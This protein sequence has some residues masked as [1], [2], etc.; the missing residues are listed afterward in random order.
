M[1]LPNLLLIAALVGLLG[2][3]GCSD[4][5]TNPGGSGGTAGSGGSGASGGTGGMAGTGGSAGMAGMG[6]MSGGDCTEG[7]L[8]CIEVCIGSEVFR[9]V[10]LDEYDDCIAL[11]ELSEEEC[12]A[13]ATETCTG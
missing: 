6:G 1:K 8:C 13:F 7:E 2:A 5:N 4:D 9:N 3:L 12:R 10:C 11:G